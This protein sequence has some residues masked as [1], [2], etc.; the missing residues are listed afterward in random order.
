MIP[1]NSS[2]PVCKR[3]GIP[4][5][6]EQC[7][8]C[9]ADL[10]CFQ[11]LDSLADYADQP[12]QGSGQGSDR[13]VKTA[14]SVFL[15][16]VSILLVS[17]S[18]SMKKSIEELEQ[19]FAGLSTEM[20]TAGQVSAQPGANAASHTAWLTE[21]VLPAF[22]ELQE[23]HAD[24]L[25]QIREEM[26]AYSAAI[27]RISAT[28]KTMQAGNVQRIAAIDNQVKPQKQPIEW[29]PSTESKDDEPVALLTPAEVPVDWE[30]QGTP[31]AE[32]D[33]VA[34]AILETPQLSVPE[35]SVLEDPQEPMAILADNRTVN[36]TV[37]SD[38]VAQQA[39]SDVL[40]SQIVET[41]TKPDNSSNMDSDESHFLSESPEADHD[42]KKP[43]APSA[44]IDVKTLVTVQAFL[45]TEPT[46]AE[47]AE[48][49]AVK[50]VLQQTDPDTFVYQARETDTLW[51]IAKRF[52]GKGRYYPVIM[53]QNPQL[54]ISDIGSKSIMSLFSDPAQVPSIYADKT[55]R[56]GGMLLWKYTVQPEDTQES[57]SSRFSL[58]IHQKLFFTDVRQIHPGNTIKIILQ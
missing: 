43:D 2:C 13:V 54:R 41:D 10:T 32:K 33:V 40:I 21:D 6:S 11:A 34:V 16:A 31:V 14:F 15:I 24:E 47:V 17:L 57:I 52:Y 1:E 19:R 44:A 22:K 8:Q 7:P 20:K 35:E 49:E 5:N 9:D 36:K 29:H 58:S 27:D 46:F 53:E 4:P 26:A 48:V 38:A 37:R 12:E 39:S 56:K 50:S 55:E 18:W 45:E 42:L 23:G 51:G 3:E 25:R 30:K 28:L